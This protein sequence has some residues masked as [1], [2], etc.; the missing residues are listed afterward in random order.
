VAADDSVA[1]LR[2]LM[3]QDTLEGVFAELV[4]KEDPE[5]VARDIAE[6]ASRRA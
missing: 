1:R 6:V 5:R 2:D 3:A 4:L